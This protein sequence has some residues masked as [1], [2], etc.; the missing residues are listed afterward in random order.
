MVT[1]E[2]LACGTPR[3]RNFLRPRTRARRQRRHRL[4][5]D[6]EAGLVD[7]L[8]SIDEIDRTQC[9]MPS[10]KGSSP[11]GRWQTTSPFTSA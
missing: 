1:I 10:K 4:H 7:A 2:A 9:R 3:C 11:T 6:T 5:P 8:Y